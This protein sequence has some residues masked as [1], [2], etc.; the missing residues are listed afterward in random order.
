MIVLKD[1]IWVNP[2]DPISESTISIRIR[3]G[4]VAE[5]GTTLEEYE[6]EKIIDAGGKF[7]SPGWIDLKCN[8]GAP[9]RPENESK[10]S[11]F[12][13]AAAGGFTRIQMQPSTKP[14]LQS[15]ESVV[16]YK[17][18]NNDFGIKLLVSAAATVDLEGRK[19][20][21][22]LTLRQA[23]AD[24]FSSVYPIVNASFFSRLLLY[25]QHSDAVL[26]HQSYDPTFTAGGQMHEGE[27]SDR[28]GLSGIPSLAEDVMIERDISIVG[29]TG[30]KLHIPCVSTEMSIRNLAQSKKRLADL[31]FSIAAHQLAFTHDALDD[32][33]TVHKVFPPYRQESDR[34]ELIKATKQGLPDAIV[35]DHTPLHYDYKDIEFENAAFGISSLETT[36][37]SLMTYV[38]DLSTNIQVQL[39]S[40]GPRRILGLENYKLIKDAPAEF[41]LFSPESHWI[42]RKENWQS[43]SYNN[44]FLGE[45]MRGLV[46]GIL[47]STGFHVNPHYAKQT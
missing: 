37:S 12:R 38:P 26:F 4:T 46:Y 41:T 39:L 23:G 7:C 29:Y 36:Y 18:W 28:R 47:T 25:L 42:P 30:G 16:Y 34:Q 8:A 6:N 20:A 43:K 21:E 11:I 13:A 19:M 10:E 24:S 3:N 22:I 32:F 31:S 35:S 17:N 14:V 2:S 15:L 1:C 44:P 40:T 33:N 27:I 45:K 9:G 5:I